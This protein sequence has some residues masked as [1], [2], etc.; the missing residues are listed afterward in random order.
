MQA[1]NGVVSWDGDF[2]NLD[3]IQ[4]DGVLVQ[5]SK[6]QKNSN[7]KTEGAEN[8]LFFPSLRLPGDHRFVILRF[9]IRTI[10]SAHPMSRPISTSR[11]Y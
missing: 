10:H 5:A 8:L 1:T 3:S 6:E 7:P 4:E 2:Q 9:S 11:D